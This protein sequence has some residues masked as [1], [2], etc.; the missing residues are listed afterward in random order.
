VPMTLPGCAFD[1]RRI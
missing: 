1:A